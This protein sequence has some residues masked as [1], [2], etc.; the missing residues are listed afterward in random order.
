MLI[1]PSDNCE[2]FQPNDTDLPE[3][4]FTSKRVLCNGRR[5]THDHLDAWQNG[6]LPDK[7][8]LNKIAEWFETVQNEDAL[9]IS[10]SVL[11][12]HLVVASERT[13]LS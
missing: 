10:W 9:I 6:R 3:T 1:S 8:S 12:Y 11:S 13:V 4:A 5:V 7:N 2:S